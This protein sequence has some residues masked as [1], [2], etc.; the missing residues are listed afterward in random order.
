MRRKKSPAADNAA[1][2]GSGWT[3]RKARK[4]AELAYATDM[5]T[6][7]RARSIEAEQQENSDS[8]TERRE[9]G[10]GQHLP[11]TT[12]LLIGFTAFVVLGIALVIAVVVIGTQI[13]FYRNEMKVQEVDL[14]KLGID[15]PL[16]LPTFTPIATEGVAWACTLMAVVLV[17][18]N[19]PSGIWTKSMWFFS[20]INAAVN[21]WHA[22]DTDNDLLGA[23]VKGGL[24]IAG[25]FIVH[26]FILWVRH[27]MTGKTLQEA[28]H[29]LVIKWRS[30]GRFLL[31]VLGV[32]ADHLTHPLIARRAFS[33]WR[34]YRG[35]TYSTA[36]RAAVAEKLARERQRHEKRSRRSPL[37]RGKRS[38]DSES[39]EGEQSDDDVEVNGEQVNTDGANASEPVNGEHAN[40]PEADGERVN[41]ERVNAQGVNVFGEQDAFTI[42]PVTLKAF[43]M[44][45]KDFNDAFAELT[46]EMN[47]NDTGSLWGRSSVLT[48]DERVND[49]GASD[50][51]GAID[52]EVNASGEHSGEQVNGSDEQT[53]VNARREV[54]AGETNTGS[55]V[56]ARGMNAQGGDERSGVNAAEQSA[57]NTPVPSG[58]RSEHGSVNARDA[59]NGERRE[60]PQVSGVNG[61]QVNGEQA[62]T[63]A[64]R[65]I[66][67]Y[68]KLVDAG[69]DMQSV[70]K[71]KVAKELEIPAGTVRRV[72]GQCL[73]GKHPRP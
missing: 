67:H 59:V 71:S 40:V 62:G 39:G 49:D 7:A 16:D 53:D 36:W 6:D 43:M 35:A 4:T 20:G 66:A 8:T 69:V 33:L 2:Q 24:S 44:S 11:F 5:L 14:S 23:V 73:K 64:S 27:V 50:V 12:R 72:W 37:A 47:T 52:G 55:E 22:L 45:D 30:F 63:N 17:M 28:R 48:C 18:L 38:R 1:P 15:T 31:A 13:G 60:R 54:N 3:S 42:D 32:V 61:R 58:E 56:N 65:V 29:D 25:P 21:A 57:A 34:L 70:N 26:L 9:T 46:R 51:N 19:R 10:A 68:W 41:G